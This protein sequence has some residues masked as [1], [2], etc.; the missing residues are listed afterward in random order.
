M[1][2][3]WNAIDPGVHDIVLF[4]LNRDDDANLT[5]NILFD[6]ILNAIPDQ[7]MKILPSFD[8]KRHDN[9]RRKFSFQII[10]SN[11]NDLVCCK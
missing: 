11:E 7:N 6:E 10:I 3:E 2:N 4:R 8:Q 5:T 1:I 9:E